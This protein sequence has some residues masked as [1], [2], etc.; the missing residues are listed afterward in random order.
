MSVEREGQKWQWTLEESYEYIMEIENF[1]D[2][3]KNYRNGQRLKS[4][5]IK[6]GESTFE[7]IICPC[8]DDAGNKDNVSVFLR[9]KNSVKNSNSNCQKLKKS[10]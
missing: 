1:E 9:N 6:V 3:I 2:K 4:R 5:P 7:I 8:G 10:N